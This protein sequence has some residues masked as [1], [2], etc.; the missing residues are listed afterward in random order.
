MGKSSL[1]SKQDQAKGHVNGKPCHFCGVSLLLCDCTSQWLLGYPWPTTP[2]PLPSTPLP[3][4][5]Q[6]LL[7]FLEGQ[8]GLIKTLWLFLHTLSLP[9]IQR[10]QWGPRERMKIRDWFQPASSRQRK[11]G[12]KKKKSLAGL[13]P[14]FV[15]LTRLDATME[16]ASYF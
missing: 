6:L 14:S 16:G 12:K 10:V 3:A 1:L 4:P 9:L 7:P 15:S 13:C 11:T 2:E 8:T 5:T